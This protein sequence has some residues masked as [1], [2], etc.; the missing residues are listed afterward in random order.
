MEGF[1]FCLVHNRQLRIKDLTFLLLWFVIYPSQ[2]A[3]NRIITLKTFI[4]LDD[5]LISVITSGIKNGFFMCLSLKAV[6]LNLRIRFNSP[7]AACGVEYIRRFRASRFFA[8]NVCNDR[9]TDL[10]PCAFSLVCLYNIASPGVN[11]KPG[12][13]RAKM[14]LWLYVTE[15]AALLAERPEKTMCVV[16][17]REDLCPFYNE[18]SPRKCPLLVLKPGFLWKCPGMPINFSHSR[19]LLEGWLMQHP[20]EPRGIQIK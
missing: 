3:N 9:E 8:L 6:F 17:H 5:G 7:R 1:K 4:H 18:M 2:C 15:P 14:M 10:W 12:D 19:S 11:K 13:Q 16:C 20:E